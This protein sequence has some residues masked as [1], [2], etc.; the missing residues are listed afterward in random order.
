MIEGTPA[1]VV[2]RHSRH[3]SRRPAIS[4]AARPIYRD[5]RRAIPSACESPSPR[6]DRA[7]A[8]VVFSLIALTIRGEKMDALSTGRAQRVDISGVDRIPCPSSCLDGR[9]RRVWTSVHSL[10]ILAASSR[11]LAI[12]A[13][14]RLTIPAPRHGAESGRVLRGSPAVFRCSPGVVETF[15]GGSLTS[16]QVRS[17]SVQF[18]FNN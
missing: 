15:A 13:L 16:L 4:G 10:N 6:S 1:R 5:R 12:C 2:C 9:G 17:L 11:G 14:L 7:A 3:R 18:P 8:R